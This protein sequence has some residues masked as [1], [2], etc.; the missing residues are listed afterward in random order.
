[1][2]DHKFPVIGRGSS[3][4]HFVATIFVVVL[5]VL[6]RNGDQPFIGRPHG[7]SALVR[8]G[9]RG[10]DVAEWVDVEH[11]ALKAMSDRLQS[12]PSR[13]HDDDYGFGTGIPSIF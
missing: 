2:A 7:L 9:S 12:L 13:T 4:C 6:D 3:K 11:D 5:L 1:M 10:S 8:H